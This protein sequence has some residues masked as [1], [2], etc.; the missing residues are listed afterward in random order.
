[1]IKS[2]W[3]SSAVT[4]S[5]PPVFNMLIRP[6]PPLLSW[7]YDQGETRR[8]F[9]PFFLASSLSPA[10]W[11]W[12]VLCKPFLGPCRRLSSVGSRATENL[13]GGCP[14]QLRPPNGGY[15][16]QM[17]VAK[18]GSCLSAC[19][20]ASDENRCDAL[21]PMQ[22]LADK[23]PPVFGETLNRPVGYMQAEPRNSH[24]PIPQGLRSEQ[25]PQKRCR[26]QAIY[27]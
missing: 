1:M 25:R 21:Q 26:C 5:A 8:L 14:V 10:A 9:A 6:S 3:R 15:L 13:P 24:G 19:G 17:G 11:L 22:V 2:A 18:G 12:S 7:S 27:F 16:G 20:F 23:C 4:V